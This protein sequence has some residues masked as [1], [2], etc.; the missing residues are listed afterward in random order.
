MAATATMTV[1]THYA[2]FRPDTGW[3]AALTM[4][5]PN[6]PDI[7]LLDHARQWVL[8]YLDWVTGDLALRAPP[9]EL[10]H[11]IKFGADR[12]RLLALAMPTASAADQAELAG[13]MSGEQP[14]KPAL[15]APAPENF[16]RGPLI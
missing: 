13:D 10:A 4:P 5:L 14:F 9:K 1:L 3:H 2:M 7:T 8:L 6:A 11:A 16:F 12:L 15:R